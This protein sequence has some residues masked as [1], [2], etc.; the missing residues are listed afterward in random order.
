MERWGDVLR[1]HYG[2][3]SHQGLVRPNNEDSGYAG[4]SLLLVAD[5]VGGSAA[6]EVASASVAHVLAAY[7]NR[8][9]NDDPVSVLSRAV[10]FAYTHLRE[11]TALDPSREG[12]ATTLTA[13]LSTTDGF[14]LAH[15][16]DSR[17]YLLRDA[18]LHQITRD[19][20]FVQDLVDAGEIAPQD[21]PHHPYR[22]VVVKSVTADSP[23]TAAITTLD[24]RPGDRILLCS[25]GLSDLVSDHDIAVLLAD[26]SPDEAAGLLVAAALDA[27]GRDNVTCVVGDIIDGEPHPGTGKVVGA[28]R[29]PTNLIDPTAGMADTA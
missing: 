1:F 28:H 16:G 7:A 3:R 29:N 15:V 13:I 14:A 25:D 21:I 20:T 6:G 27:G 5:G 2:A 22:S 8:T 9:E 18:A 24:L 11:G 23:P 10:D 4:P 26:G 17:G 19:D 12:M